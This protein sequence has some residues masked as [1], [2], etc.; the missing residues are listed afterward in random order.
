MHCDLINTDNSI[1]EKEEAF[2]CSLCNGTK[3]V[4][5]KDDNNWRRELEMTEKENSTFE[6][7]FTTIRQEFPNTHLV[8]ILK[9]NT[10]C[11]T[12]A[13]L[14]SSKKHI[15]TDVITELGGDEVNL[16]GVMPEIPA[17]VECTFIALRYTLDMDK[18]NV[19]KK[20]FLIEAVF[21]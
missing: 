9:G 5:I 8:F 6:E 17:E 12:T 16:D 21:P 19:I 11:F 15:F 3:G 1:N 20:E 18:K 7:L 4:R 2:I 14:A 10:M 13:K